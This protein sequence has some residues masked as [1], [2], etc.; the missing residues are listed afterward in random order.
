MASITSWNRLEPIPSTGD[1]AVSLAAPIADPMW[2]LARQW[3]VLEFAGEDAA[4]PVVVHVT[5]SE[6]A[7]GEVVLGRQG[8]RVRLDDHTA[9]LEALVEAEPFDIA[10]HERLRVDTGMHLLRLLAAGGRPDARDAFADQFRF[11]SAGNRVGRAGTAFRLVADGRGVDGALVASALR[12][13]RA[14]D[15]RLTGLPPGV[16]VTVPVEA[17]VD[18][19]GEWLEWYDGLCTSGKADSWD[20]FFIEYSAAVRT[21]TDDGPDELAVKEYAGGRLDWFSFAGRPPPETNPL[22][23]QPEPRIVTRTVIPVP[24][25]YAGMPADRF[26]EFESSR[27]NLG[28]VGAGPTD[29]ARLALVEFALVYGNDWFVVPVDLRAGSLCTITLL[30]VVDTFGEVT[31]IEPIPRD[32]GWAMFELAGSRPGESRLLIP[33]VVS[34]AVQ[35]ESIETLVLTRDEMANMAWAVERRISE[36]TG[37][38]I[39]LAERPVDAST[40]WEHLGDSAPD[41]MLV[42]RLATPVPDNWLPLVPVPDDDG[43]EGVVLERRTIRRTTSAGPVDVVPSGRLGTELLAVDEGSIPRSGVSVERSWQLARWTDG[44]TH[45]WIGRHRRVGH[46]PEHSGL[47][48]DIVDKPPATDPDA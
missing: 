36:S 1:M 14:A 33:P 45:L 28:A 13:L 20:S 39:D 42:Y 21:A 12:S 46:G 30:E 17:V 23:G 25:S 32:E 38:T 18:I 48:F 4:T 44:S 34:G 40:G 47:R 3:Q 41:D 9:P 29:L 24:A 22:D 2:L 11:E 10:D 16:D 31:T 6:S 35:G 37:D 8:E 43:G 19:A 26:W 27:V 5:A 7:L 15:G